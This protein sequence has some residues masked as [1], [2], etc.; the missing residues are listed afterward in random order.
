M[1]KVNAISISD[2]KGVRKN[3]VKSARLIENFGIENDAHGGG[4]H[5]QISLLAEKSIDFMRDKGLDVV[6]GNFAENITTGGVDLLT[7]PIGTHI[8]IGETELVIS[9]IGKIC[10]DRCAIYH[11][12]GDCVM[13]RE[14][15]F[16]IVRKGG[17]INTNDTIEVLKTRSA[18]AAIIT[19]K[20]AS[21]DLDKKALKTLNKKLGA[22][23]TRI[24][25]LK[26]DGSNLVPILTDLTTIQKIDHIYV[27][28][29]GGTCEDAF[30]AN[31]LNFKSVKY[32][33]KLKDII[34]SIEN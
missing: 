13:P 19:N 11:Q 26:T 12:A 18:S 25:T 24:D 15:I 3:N 14:G 16:A 32:F 27:Y 22:A 29:K 5:R 30:L 31:W 28:D 17:T 1:A 9:Q 20:E 7:L 33:I 4:W 6:A 23:F 2:R 21:Q 8:T 34:D 10:H